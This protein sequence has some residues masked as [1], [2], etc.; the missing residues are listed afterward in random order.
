MVRVVDTGVARPELTA[1]ID[2]ALLRARVAGACGD[3]VHL[4]RRRPPSVSIGY[5]QSASEVA[6]LG[7]C[8]R[9]G[10]PVVRRASGGGAIFTD[11][12]QLVY[13]LAWAPPKA[14][15]AREGFDLACGAV[16]VRARERLGV[17]VVTGMHPDNAAAEIYRTKVPIVPTEKTATGM[18]EA[19]SVMARLA[20][21]LAAHEPLGSP[22][23]EGYLPTGHRVFH[24][25]ARPAT[26]R[27][28]EMLLRKVRGE[29]YTTEWEVPRYTLVPPAPP[30]LGPPRAAPRA[31]ARGSP[32]Q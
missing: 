21:R 22:R 23:Q 19:L 5:F 24:E 31:S 12:R 14:V 8:R 2:E 30:A 6:D 1:A 20:L 10:V 25:A 11:D 15:T 27:A 4:Y 7:A 29:R 3:T 9:D 26:D 17:A 13:A 28:V 32:P 16:A 18:A